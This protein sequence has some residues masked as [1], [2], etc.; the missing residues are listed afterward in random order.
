MNPSV[1][2]IT[3]EVDS[4]HAPFLSKGY[5]KGLQCQECG[6]MYPQ[7]AAYVCEECFGGLEVAYDDAV[8]DAVAAWKTNRR[9]KNLW[10]YRELLPLDGA[11]CV[12][13]TS[14]FT[15]LHPAKNLAKEWGCREI[16][17]KDD[18][19]NSP[20]LSYKDR[21]VPVAISKAKELGFKVASCASTGNLANAVSAHAARAGMKRVIFI[22]HDLEANKIIGSL[23]FEPLV[24]A[25]RGTYDDVN[26][27]C[28]QLADTYPWA[29]VNVNLRT[30]YTEGAKTFGYEVAEQMGWHF[31]AHM[32]VPVAGGTILPKIWKAFKELK[33]FGLVQDDLPCIYAAQAAGCAPVATALMENTDTIRPVKEP[34]TIAKS[35]AIGDPADGYMVLDTVR[36]SG[37]AGEMALEHE[38]VEGIRTLARTEGIFTETAGG[39]TMACTQKLVQNKV[40][41]SDEPIVISIT[42]NGYKTVEPLAG[43]LGKVQTIEPNVK[44]FRSI[45]GGLVDGWDTPA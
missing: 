8:A 43:H 38:I 25:V 40:I 37:G 16:Y 44:S 3:S 35:I 34:K 21:V 14:G 17:I 30:Y 28:S 12:G 6:T 19:V 24:V 18:T 26:R 11:P 13:F 7:T 23:V 45:C 29:F 20:T 41:P 1:A 32:V 15:P 27:L 39:V 42:G 10:R 33:R 9:P 22:P 36:E 5:V 4:A 2:G 31:P